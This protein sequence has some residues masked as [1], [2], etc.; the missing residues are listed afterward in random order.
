VEAAY[1]PASAGIL[2]GVLPVG[3]SPARMP[4]LPESARGFMVL[5]RVHKTA[6]SPRVSTGSRRRPASGQLLQ[7]PHGNR[8]F[9]DST[10]QRFNAFNDSRLF[11]VTLLGQSF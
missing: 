3:V 6:A 1:E 4:A 7:R 9:H 10:I 5:M 8:R 2:A 11:P